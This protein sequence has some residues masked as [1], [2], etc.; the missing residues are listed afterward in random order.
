MVSI[1]YQVL[2]NP[3]KRAEYEEKRKEYKVE[4]LLDPLEL[5]GEEFAENASGNDSNGSDLGDD[6]EDEEE[7]KPDEY[8]KQLYRL[9]TP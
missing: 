7:A 9:A 2:S 6:S 4:G 3:R 1:A 8:R 5:W